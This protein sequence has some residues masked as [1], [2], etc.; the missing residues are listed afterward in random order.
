MAR[1]HRR[2]A[3]PTPP[4]RPAARNVRSKKQSRRTL[5]PAT[6]G[7]ARLRRATPGF[8][9]KGGGRPQ[10]LSNGRVEGQLDGGSRGSDGGGLNRASTRSGLRGFDGAAGGRVRLREPA[11]SAVYRQPISAPTGDLQRPVAAAPPTANDDAPSGG[12]HECNDSHGI[13][14]PRS[15]GRVGRRDSSPG[16]TPCSRTAL[17]DRAGPMSR[18]NPAQQPT[19]LREEMPDALDVHRSDAQRGAWSEST[20]PANA[21]CDR[22]FQLLFAISDCRATSRMRGPAV[23]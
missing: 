8:S 23:S 18:P 16:P 22:R 20:M 6:P 4:D 13:T 7:I 3:S 15:N 2:V 5:T 19:M 14:A 1:R 17:S 12:Q 10:S 9:L 11:P 21:S